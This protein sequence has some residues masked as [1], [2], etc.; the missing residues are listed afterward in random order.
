MGTIKLIDLSQPLKQTPPGAALSVDIDYIDHEAGANI[1]GKVFGINMAD[2]PE[3]K[4]SAVE[5]LTLSS[6]SGTHL[7]APW[8]YW[9]TS[10]GKPARTIDEIP[11]EW[12]F[13]RRGS[14]GSNP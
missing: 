13:Q 1:F 9:P 6:H 7:D 14:T 10:E 12:L 11:L 8:H 5:K 3:G 2:F 4:F